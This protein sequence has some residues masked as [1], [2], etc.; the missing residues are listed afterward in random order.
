[1][2]NEIVKNYALVKN[3]I[4]ENI[5]VWDGVTPYNPIGYEKIEILPG[6]HCDTGY[7]YVDG[8]F[9]APVIEPPVDPEA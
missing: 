1:M 8:I 9:T 3:G 4:V 5:V 7:T 2:G 6:V